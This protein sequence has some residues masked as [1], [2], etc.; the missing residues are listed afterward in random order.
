MY[1]YIHGIIMHRAKIS[2]TYV[3]IYMY[4]HVRTYTMATKYTQTTL[5]IYNVHVYVTVL[6][7]QT[8]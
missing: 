1:M 5:H 8:P 3:R 6:K 4:I 7:V 2:W